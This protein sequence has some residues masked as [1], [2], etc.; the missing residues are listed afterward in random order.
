MNWYFSTS[1]SHPFSLSS[2]NGTA[3]RFSIL[4]TPQLSRSNSITSSVSQQSRHS[5]SP[6]FYSSWFLCRCVYARAC[7]PL[8]SYSSDNLLD[9][10]PYTPPDKQIR[11]SFSY[12]LYRHYSFVFLFISQ[13]EFKLFSAHIYESRFKLF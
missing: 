9:Q 11:L 2:T 6:S 8:D 1:K 5:L 3:S 10:S 4:V 7:H 12:Q 13:N